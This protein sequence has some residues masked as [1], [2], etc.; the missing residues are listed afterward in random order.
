MGTYNTYGNTQI[1]VGN[2]MCHHFKIGDKVEIP[3]GIYVDHD[4]AIVINNGI[5]IAE[6]FHITSKWGD[7]IKCNKV[8][9]SKD[10]IK[11]IIKKELKKL[12]I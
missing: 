6:Y 7:I 12:K 10:H 9:E 5:F 2:L 8:I 1:K 3:D 4:S 11:K